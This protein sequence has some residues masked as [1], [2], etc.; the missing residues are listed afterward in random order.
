MLYHHHGVAQFLQLSQHLDQSGGVTAVESDAR[1]IQ[2]IHASHQRR[3]QVGGQV[4]ALAFTSGKGIR[5]SV[6]RKIAQT[7]IQQEL[8]AMGNLGEQALGYLLF[9]IR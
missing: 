1:L 7:H 5:E 6:E 9:V 2:D 3:P 8:Q 4:D